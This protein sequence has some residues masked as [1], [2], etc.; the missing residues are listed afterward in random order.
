[1]KYA[2]GSYASELLTLAAQDYFFE[3][4]RYRKAYFEQLTNLVPMSR[5]GSLRGA[6]REAGELLDQ[7]KT[8]LIFPEGTRGSGG[9]L[10]SFKPA[11]GYLA[12]HHSVDILPIWLEGTSNALPKGSAFPRSREIEARIGR[13][14]SIAA[15]REVTQ[16]LN[17]TDSARVVSRI[18]HMAVDSLRRSRSLNLEDVDVAAIRRAEVPE[19]QGLL[20]V[21]DEMKERFVAG[22]IDEPLSYYFSLGDERWTVRA[23]KSELEVAKGK[24]MAAADCVLK[25]SPAIFERIIRESW[26]PG[27][28]DFVSGQIKTNNVAHLLTMQKIFRL[29]IPIEKLR[30][31]G[32][33]P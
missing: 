13:P 7:G 24:T 22:A 30:K 21:F 4:N 29:A 17:P 3:G 14:L 15:L 1:V 23:T 25:T 32:A 16:G 11:M 10:R 6:L 19:E 2:L 5:S 31:E 18:A 12:L 27:P 28:S 9:S 20:P 8:V 26:V 33:T